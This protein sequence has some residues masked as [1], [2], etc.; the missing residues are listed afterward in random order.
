MD[1]HPLGKQSAPGADSQGP[2]QKQN[3][4]LHSGSSEGQRADTR[5]SQVRWAREAAW[6]GRCEG[7]LAAQG[8][9][10]KVG[11]PSEPAQ[12]PSPV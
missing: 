5:G 11:F 9:P 3:W 12:M 6:S 4:K 8:I 10:T 7:W 2:P 1:T